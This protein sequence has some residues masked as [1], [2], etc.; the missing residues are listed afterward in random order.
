MALAN[1]P[2]RRLLIF[3]DQFEEIFTACTDV[4]WRKRFVELLLH[5]ARVANGKVMIVI[6]IRLDFLGKCV[7]HPELSGIISGGMELVGAMNDNELEAAIVSPAALA[8]VEISPSLVQTL[9]QACP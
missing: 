8:G 7:D 6:T 9:I 4:E 2:G 5:A 1:Q 3:I